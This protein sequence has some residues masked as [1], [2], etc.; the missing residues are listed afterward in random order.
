LSR[1]PSLL[2][3]ERR[4][5][6]FLTAAQERV[7]N[8]RVFAVFPLLVGCL[9]AQ[10]DAASTVRHVKL[11]LRFANGLCD[12]T[13]RVRLSGI[14]GPVA[15]R[16][17]DDRCEVDFPN[18][19]TGTYQVEVSGQSFPA[20]DEVIST[21]N[22]TTDFELKVMDANGTL[23]LSPGSP[24]VSAASLQIPAKALKEF[25]KSNEL[26]SRRDFPK[27]IQTLNRAIAIYPSYAA[28][29]NNLGAVYQRI[30]DQ[31]KERAALEKAVE[32]DDHLGAAYLNLGRMDIADSNFRAAEE[33]LSKAAA[34]NP[35]DP[36][37]FELLAYSQFQDQHVDDAIQ[38]AHKAHALAGPHSSVHLVAAKAF[39]QKRD[40]RGAI[41]ELELFLS[42][43][44]TGERAQQ[45]K[46]D[47]AVLR[48]IR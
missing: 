46:K 37:A 3:G 23:N 1:E 39:E 13:A 43:E 30:G 19:P 6:S 35:N 22:G 29:Y 25:A 18:L 36:I 42:E 44:P 14:S 2:S 38:T 17:P 15:D 47:L 31:A 21:T 48:S 28:A 24:V 20:T 33:K 5:N 9:I 16:T 45:A 27:A 34:D 32:L 7:M 4:R 8:K 11:R 12:P 26:I 10:F 41:A 40:A